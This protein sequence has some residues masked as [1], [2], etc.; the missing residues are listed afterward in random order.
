VASDASIEGDQR[1]RCADLVGRTTEPFERSW[2]AADARLY[3][4]S[5]GAGS[6]D[7]T[8]ELE[9]TVEDNN[10]RPQR[11]LPTFA[12][13]A[14]RRHPDAYSLLPAAD[15]GKVIMAGYEIRWPEPTLI[16]TEAAITLTTEVAGVRAHKSGSLVTFETRSRYTNGDIAFV[17]RATVLVRDYSVLGAPIAES[18]KIARLCVTGGGVAMR[19]FPQQALIHRLLGDANPLHSEPRAA[20]NAGYNRPILHG[21]C[22]LGLAARGLL[23]RVCPGQPERFK[24][25]RVDFRAPVIPGQEVHLWTSESGS[26][27]YSFQVTLAPQTA[28]ALAGELDLY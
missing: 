4:L 2:G 11:V 3:A 25:L 1:R 7:P 28:V 14:G 27:G 20:V 10:G 18:R 23:R 12:S 26:S 9:Y 15:H 5:V 13:V 24:R 17:T 6:E 22:T 19:T 16:P 8:S 21:L